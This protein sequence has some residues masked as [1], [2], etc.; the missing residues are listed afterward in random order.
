MKKIFTLITMMLLTFVAEANAEDSYIVAGV[1]T[2]FGTNWSPKDENN[3]MTSVG[4]GLM[5][6]RSLMS[7]C[8]QILMSIRSLR[9]ALHGCREIT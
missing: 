6:L 1:Q 2:I 9:T 8:S 3:L 5:N 7:H 4:G